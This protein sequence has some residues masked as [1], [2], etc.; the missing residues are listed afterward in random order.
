VADLGA[1]VPTTPDIKISMPYV[2]I[3]YSVSNVESTLVDAAS[4]G[5]VAFKPWKEEVNA[6]KIFE[7]MIR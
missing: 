4:N 5:L 7:S 1:R 6:F 3:M 2:F